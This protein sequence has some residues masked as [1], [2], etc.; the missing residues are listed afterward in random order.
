MLEWRKGIMSKKKKIIIGSF[1]AAVLILLTSFTMVIGKQTNNETNANSPLFA[2]RIQNTINGEQKSVTSYYLGKGKECKIS[3][4]NRDTKI[5]LLQKIIE[6]ISKMNDAQLAELAFLIYS[7]KIVKENTQQ[8]LRVLYQLKNNPTEIK[9]Q[10]SSIPNDCSHIT[11][12]CPPTTFPVC[13]P[14]IDY[15]VLGCALFLVY[16]ILINVYDFI[17][18]ILE[19]G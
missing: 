10:L 18:Y 17:I 1:G 2:I 16:V 5:D 19:G 11:K 12:G 14:T 3:V 7:N 4:I 9:K 6:K 15:W 13:I 8:I